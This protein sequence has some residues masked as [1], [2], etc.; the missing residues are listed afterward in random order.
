M[1]AL[2][3]QFSNTRKILRLAHGVEPY[4]ELKELIQE[5]PLPSLGLLMGQGTSKVA[6]QAWPD[7]TLHCL[8]FINAAVSLVN[9]VVD[10]VICLAKI[11]AID[12][13]WS[14]RLDLPSCQLWM[15]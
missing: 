14:K 2:A 3:S 15:M 11:G 4:L 9:D 8:A 10:D 6:L 1:T 12:K 5:G 13:S 7:R